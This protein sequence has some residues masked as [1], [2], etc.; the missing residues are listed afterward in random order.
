[1]IS[2]NIFR[3]NFDPNSLKFLISSKERH[4]R[5]VHKIPTAEQKKLIFERCDKNRCICSRCGKRFST[6]TEKDQHENSMKCSAIAT[7][8]RLHLTLKEKLDILT[9]CKENDTMSKRKIALALSQKM[10]RRISATTVIR[11]IEISDRILN[12]SHKN[13]DSVRVRTP[14]ELE[15]ET[16]V[17][18]KL[19]E[20]VQVRECQIFVKHYEFLIFLRN[21]G[22]FRGECILDIILNMPKTISGDLAVI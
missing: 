22:Y 14:V 11:L 9:F 21:L 1:M 16:R 3:T 5:N 7:K 2:Q 18:A 20:M 12:S 8:E 10:N 4:L 19:K 17:V 6:S 15:F 13:L